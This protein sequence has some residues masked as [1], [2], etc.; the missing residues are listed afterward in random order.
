MTIAIDV[1]AVGDDAVLADVLRLLPQL[2]TTA[3]PLTAAHFADI[4]AT[5]G[6]SVMVARQGGRVVGTLTLVIFSVPTGVRAWIE[7]VVVDEAA[8]GSGLGEALVRAAIERATV[9][10]ARTL[11][12]TSRPDRTVANRLYQRLGFAVRNTNVYRLSLVP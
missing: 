11:E 5:P 12:L 4:V 6:T 1:V 10:G 9:A 3:P 8:R 7:D 2:T